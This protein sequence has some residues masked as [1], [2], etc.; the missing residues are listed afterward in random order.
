MQGLDWE[1]AKK[2]PR[3]MFPKIPR[4][5]FTHD[6]EQYAYENYDKV[7]ASFTGDGAAFENTNVPT[8]SKY[9]P[10]TMDQLLDDIDHGRAV[11]LD[12][13]WS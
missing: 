5:I 13:D 1:A 10:W 8:G 11:Q 2:D 12:G 7:V 6:P 4:W 3:T 9:Q